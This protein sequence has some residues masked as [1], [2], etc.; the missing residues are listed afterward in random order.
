MKRTSKL[1]RRR[2]RQGYFY[3]APFLIGFLCF[4]LIPLIQSVWFSFSEIGR[5]SCRERVLRLV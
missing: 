5:A 1:I 4:L 3:I 2:N